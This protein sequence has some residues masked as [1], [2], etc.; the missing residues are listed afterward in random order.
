MTVGEIRGC[1]NSI[2]AKML[3]LFPEEAFIK[4]MWCMLI[5]FLVHFMILI[6]CLREMHS[7]VSNNVFLSPSSQAPDNYNS[8]FT[9]PGFR[10]RLPR[11][12]NPVT[13]ESAF[14]SEVDQTSLFPELQVCA[15]FPDSGE[16]QLV[17]PLHRNSAAALFLQQHLFHHPVN[18][19][20]R[21]EPRPTGEIQPHFCLALR[22][23]VK[24]FYVLSKS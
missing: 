6:V 16:L 18:L 7:N 14:G 20:A 13:S 9:L 22:A 10:T 5:L 17:V 11:K 12:F 8:S 21:R 1:E 24:L 3:F 19:V 23:V 4:L 15:A 2:G